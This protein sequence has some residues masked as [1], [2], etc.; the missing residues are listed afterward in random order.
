MPA[1]D[2]SVPRE[3]RSN[4]YRVALAPAGVEAFVQAGHRLFIEHD[5]GVGAGFSDE[6]YRA[7]GA[8][9]VYSH[10]EAYARGKLVVKVARPTV[11]DLQLMHEDQILVGFLHLAAGRRDKIEILRSRNV[12][13]I[14]WETVERENGCLPVLHGMS[15]LA[16]RL[17][18]QIVG[19]FMQ[20]NEGG[21]GV[22]LG[23]TPTVP[24]AEVVIIGAGTFGTA[25]ALALAGNRASVYVLDINSDALERA[26]RRLD[27]RGVTLAAT[28]YNLRKVVK[29]ADA[30]I[31]AV[32]VPGQRAPIL[33]PR[34][35]LRTMRPRS[36]FV[37]ASIDQGGCAETS[38]PTTH[39]N[40]TYLEEGILHYCVPNITS[41]VGRSATHALTYAVMPYLLAI[42]NLGLEAA[43]NQHP[44]LARGI[45]IRDGQVV[46]P[47]LRADLLRG[48]AA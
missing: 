26:H 46:H 30:L 48:D 32:Y 40:P 23:G 25:S 17:M 14:G 3:K 45:N 24:P 10:E 18:P 16:G 21:R 41:I 47:G 44:E 19:R 33:L 22:A 36:L 38:R 43:L 42:A 31:G 1:I 12:C 11:E 39:A 29:F 13:A 34:E 35:L 15:M 7:A 28:D 4:E 9:I 8:Q 6:E 2:I 20:S 5:A 37:D 27:G